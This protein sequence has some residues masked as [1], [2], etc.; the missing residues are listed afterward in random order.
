MR[1][2]NVGQLGQQPPYGYSMPPYYWNCPIYQGQAMPNMPPPQIQY[3]VQPYTPMPVS[4]EGQKHNS[5]GLV[6]VHYT[7]GD[8]LQ[9]HP[10]EIQ[11]NRGRPRGAAEN[12]PVNAFQGAPCSHLPMYNS[13][14]RR[15]GREQQ[16]QRNRYTVSEKQTKELLCSLIQDEKN[17]KEYYIALSRKAN[18]KYE[19]KALL[20]IADACKRNQE[21]LCRCHKAMFHED[22]YA[23][24]RQV[25][26]D[27]SL[28]DGIFRAI[29]T[30]NE[31]FYRFYELWENSEQMVQGDLFGFYLIQ[32]YKLHYL[33]YLK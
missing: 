25:D 1:W 12:Q 6:T 24:V 10:N 13:T 14:L 33:F 8:V 31:R 17:G 26:T 5:D 11:I 18:Q 27:I 9:Q 23:E 22:F 29:V 7:N 2:R 28:L 19:E 30:E 4:K 15:T 3:P 16:E 32:E 21:I 20:F